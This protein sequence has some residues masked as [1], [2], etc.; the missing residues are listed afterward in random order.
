M[1]AWTLLPPSARPAYADALK[2]DHD[3][4]ARGRGWCLWKAL[5]TVVG[6]RGTDPTAAAE[7]RRVIHEVLTDPVR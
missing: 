5:I 4:W 2:L 7:A 6:N 1:L 3:T